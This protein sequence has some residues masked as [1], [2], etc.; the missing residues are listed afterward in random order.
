[1][2]FRKLERQLQFQGADLGSGGFQLRHPRS[3]RHV[4]RDNARSDLE[5]RTQFVFVERLHQII[6]RPRFEPFDQTLLPAARGEQDNIKNLVRFAHALADSMPSIPG[7]IQSITAR[8]GVTCARIA[9]IASRPSLVTTT[10]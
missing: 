3:Q 2:G 9:S 8:A 1:M 4:Q 7:I 6:I 10:R 5:A